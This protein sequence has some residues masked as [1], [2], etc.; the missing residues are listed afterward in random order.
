MCVGFVVNNVF[1]A[2]LVYIQSQSNVEEIIK[3]S[4][5]QLKMFESSHEILGTTV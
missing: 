2:S 4:I 1:F 5:L 3:G